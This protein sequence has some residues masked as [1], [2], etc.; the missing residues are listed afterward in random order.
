MNTKYLLKQIRPYVKDNR[1]TYDDF[2]KLFGFLER[3][4]QYSIADAIHDELKIELVDEIDS[5]PE[6]DEIPAENCFA[7]CQKTRR[8]KSFKQIFDSL[9][10]K[11]RRTGASRSLRQKQ[12]TCRQIRDKIFEKISVQ[13]DA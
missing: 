9:D 7:D 11:R 8:D 13:V 2:D 10:S 6:E 3:R 12:R 5:P 4:E 1:L